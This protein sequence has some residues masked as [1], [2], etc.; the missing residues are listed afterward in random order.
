LKAY[1][2]ALA[3]AFTLSLGSLASAGPLPKGTVIVSKTAPTAV[4][5]WD[6]TPALT[7]LTAAHTSDGDKFKSLE[8]DAVKIL[9]D[10]AASLSADTV[11]LHILYAKTNMGAEYGDPTMDEKEKLVVL[12]AKR[13]TIAPSSGA[14]LQGIA[15][16]GP[17]GGLKIDVTGKLPPP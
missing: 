11:E 2:P 15:K 12:T 10:R 5:L 13:S 3:L 17:T 16:G 8:E 7:E 9:V 14:W 6:A 1:G 4:L